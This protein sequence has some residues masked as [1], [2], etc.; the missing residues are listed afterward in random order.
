MTTVR[1]F[2]LARHGLV[3]ALRAINIQPG[4]AVA[5]PALICRDVLAS[6]NTVGARP[7]FYH[8]DERLRPLAIPDDKEIRAVI[9]VNYFGFAQDLVPFIQYCSSRKAILIEDN[10]HG[11]LSADETGRRLGTRSAIGITSVRKSIRIPDGAILSVNDSRLVERIHDQLPTTSYPVYLFR[12]RR[13]SAIIER[14]FH[15]PTL[16]IFRTI[17]RIIRTLKTG[18]SLP[19][20]SATSETESL[21]LMGPHKLSLQ[22]LERLDPDAETRRRHK[23]FTQV[24]QALSG[25]SLTPLYSELPQGTVPYGYPFIS[26]DSTMRNAQR[27]IARHGVEIIRWPDLP[28]AIVHSAPFHYTNLWLVNFL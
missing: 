24:H 1:Y 3:E 18:S 28:D 10:A 2:S 21:Q 16:R 13:L 12:V 4:E 27:R 7:V 5:L 15:V 11:Y 19:V 9:A 17:S 22:L 23:L 26:D 6:L 8:V 14:R 25:L 20:S